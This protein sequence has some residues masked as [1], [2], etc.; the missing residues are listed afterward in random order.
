LAGLRQVRLL[1]VEVVD[2]EEGRRAFAGGGRQDGRVGE[3]KVVVVE[4]VA[5]GAHDRVAH[6]EDRV[7]AARAQPE[8][9]VI[10]QKLC[11]VFLRRDRVALDRLQHFRADDINLVSARRAF[12]CAHRA[13]NRER[14]FLTEILERVPQFF[15]DSLFEDDALHDARPVAQLRKQEFAA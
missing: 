10:H 13:A 5:D 8:V 12:V 1:V 15:R 4:E 2:L 7:L 11:A 3:R 9:A 14:G 6:F